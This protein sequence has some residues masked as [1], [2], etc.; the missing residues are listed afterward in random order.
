MPIISN[1]GVFGWIIVA[2]LMLLL[3]DEKTKKLG[4]WAII[5]MV[6]IQIVVSIIKVTVG[7]PHPFETSHQVHVLDP[8]GKYSFPSG[9]STL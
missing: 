4:I 2:I 9:H 7:E 8:I 1:I 5:T 3:E 6:I